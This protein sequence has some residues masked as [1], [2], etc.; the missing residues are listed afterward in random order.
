MQ[1]Y[2]DRGDMS[3]PAL[4]D[5]ESQTDIVLSRRQSELQKSCGYAGTTREEG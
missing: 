3:W 4:L 1:I 2:G 5:S